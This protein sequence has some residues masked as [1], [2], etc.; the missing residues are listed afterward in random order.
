MTSHARE[1]ERERERDREKNS[2]IV[3]IL[4]QNQVHIA[5]KETAAWNGDDLS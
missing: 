1:R 4:A 5:D 3:Q 2:S